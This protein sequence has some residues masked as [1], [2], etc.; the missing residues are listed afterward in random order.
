MERRR[1]TVVD[2]AVHAD[3]QGTLRQLDR[4]QALGLL[5]RGERSL[6]NEFV[7][8]LDLRAVAVAVFF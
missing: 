6:S 2:D 5:S 8:V 7:D 3:G 1:V 4:L